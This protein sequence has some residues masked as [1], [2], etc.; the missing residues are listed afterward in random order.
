MSGESGGG[1]LG[2]SKE[3]GGS[4]VGSSAGPEVGA[5]VLVLVEGAG[6]GG[7]FAWWEVM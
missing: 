5:L 7:G 6:G 1:V 3:G 2:A 4:W